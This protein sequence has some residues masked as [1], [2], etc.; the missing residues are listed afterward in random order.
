[1]QMKQKN[2]E[3][4][5][6]IGNEAHQAVDGGS[7]SFTSKRLRTQIYSFESSQKTDCLE[8]QAFYLKMSLC[9]KNSKFMI[10]GK[11]F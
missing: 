4:A 6:K 11:I 10:F 1:M 3:I 9:L 7:T 2:S 8:W 5:T